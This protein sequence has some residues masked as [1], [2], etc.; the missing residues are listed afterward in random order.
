MISEKQYKNAVFI[1]KQYNREQRQKQLDLI[2]TM[3]MFP[4]GLCVC[5][6]KTKGIIGKV[7]RYGYWNGVPSLILENGKKILATNAVKI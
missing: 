7:A 4:I 2:I 3:S 1:I 5:S 6:K